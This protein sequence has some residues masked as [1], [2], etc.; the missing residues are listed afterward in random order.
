MFCNDT[1][2][3]IFSLVE[4]QYNKMKVLACLEEA[5][6]LV[7]ILIQ[8]QS[9]RCAFPTAIRFKLELK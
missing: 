9:S 4:N 8:I 5:G 3:G 2:T 7:A 1:E 6:D